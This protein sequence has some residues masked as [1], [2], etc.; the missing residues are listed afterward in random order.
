MIIDIR[1]ALE[2]VTPNAMWDFS[3]PN[4]GGTEFQYENIKWVDQRQ[5][6]SWDVLVSIAS[7]FA[8]SDLQSRRELMKCSALQFRK[9]LRLTGRVDNF[10]AY[11]EQASEEIVETWEYSTEISRTDQLV[12]DG[13]ASLGMNDEDIDSIFDLAKTL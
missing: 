3:I 5:K 1:R 4:E 13:M 2:V 11:L 8:E 12:V 6:P 9:A 10:K 7:C